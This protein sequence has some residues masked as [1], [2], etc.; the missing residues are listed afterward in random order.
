MAGETQV[1]G[2]RS[3]W[4]SWVA[5]PLQ[6]RMVRPR[7]PS[8]CRPDGGLAQQKSLRDAGLA[9]VAQEPGFVWGQ[10][11]AV[12]SAG[13]TLCGFSMHPHTFT[14]DLLSAR[15][16]VAPRP[17][18]PE[19][20]LEPK[21]SLAPSEKPINWDHLKLLIFFFNLNAEH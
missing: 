3:S 1:H 2:C 8:V 5:V 20:R 9:V 21:Q 10:F 15:R 7:E 13:P 6:G 14:R 4:A 12:F 19:P 18:Q 17:T 16:C 11:Q